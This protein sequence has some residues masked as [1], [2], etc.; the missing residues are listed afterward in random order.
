MV[1][2]RTDKKYTFSSDR[3][4]QN[5]SKKRLVKK[6]EMSVLAGIRVLDLSRFQ[7]GPVA[8]MLLGDMGAEVI[9]IEEPG[10][11]PDRSWGLLGP[12][13]ETLS[14]KIVGRNRKGITLRI[15]KSKGEKIFDELVKR[16]DV[17]LH[18]FTPGTSIAEKVNYERLREINPAIIVAAITGFGQ[19]GP[20]AKLVCFDHIAQARSGGMI[21]TGFPGDPPLKTTITYNDLG[22]G[23]FAAFGIVTALYHRERTGKGQFIDVSLFDIAFFATQCMGTLLLYK[24]YGEIR[25]QVGNLGFHSYLGCFEAKD[26]WV[27]LSGTTNPI[28]KRLMEAIGREDMA[29]DPK[30]SQNDMVRFDH[31]NLID[32]VMKEWV[33]Q[34]TVKEVV[35]ILQGARVP[36]SVVNTIDQLE[37]DPQAI[38]R[39]MTVKMNYPEIGSIPIPGLPIK[40]SLTPSSINSPAPKIGE[41]NEEI[42]C[43]LLGFSQE[44]LNKLKEESII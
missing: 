2:R 17:V 23:T 32:Q 36:C 19:N 35:S 16:S 29:N 14:Y 6:V 5:F 44:Q 28:W 41:H 31:A 40:L 38:A 20:D 43:E 8:G 39:E 24:V 18:N 4:C 26:G 30:L 13:G 33:S 27:F 7:S 25:K 11:G 15:N 10:G 3:L 21:L 34:R 12:D 37:D 1:Y 42:Y 9:R 22:A